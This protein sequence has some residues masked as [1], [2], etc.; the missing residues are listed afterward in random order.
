MERTRANIHSSRELILAS[1]EHSETSDRLI[2]EN[3]DLREFLRE[4]V[5]N[6]WS[7]REDRLDGG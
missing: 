2:Q 4:N 5:L 3:A 1:R 7:K 6:I